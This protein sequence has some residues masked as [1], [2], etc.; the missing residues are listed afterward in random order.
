LRNKV[1]I[2]HDASIRYPNRSILFA[3]GTLLYL[4]GTTRNHFYIVTLSDLTVLNIDGSISNSNNSILYSNGSVLLTNGIFID[5]ANTFLYPNGSTL[6]ENGTF[7]D[8]DGTV[9]NQNSFTNA[10]KNLVYNIDKSILNSDGTT[11][12][13]NKSLLL[14]NG[15]MKNQNESYSYPNGSIYYVNGTFINTKG[16]IENKKPA[17]VDLLVHKLDGTILNPDGTI[18]Y[19][20]GSLVLLNEIML[21][22]DRSILYPNGS[23]LFGN[24]IVTDKQGTIKLSQIRNLISIL[25]IYNPDGSRVTQDGTVFY[26]NGDILFINGTLY[27]ETIIVIFNSTTKIGIEVE[28][29]TTK[30]TTDEADI[31]TSRISSGLSTQPTGTHGEDQLTSI[32]HE[33]SQQSTKENTISSIATKSTTNEA[34]IITSR[35]SSDISTQPTGTHGEDQLTSITHEVDQQS[36]KENTISSIATKSTTNEADIITS[37]ISSALSSQLTITISVDNDSLNVITT[38]TIYSTTTK[39]NQNALTST[40]IKNCRENSHSIHCLKQTRN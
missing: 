8:N 20:N 24:G 15:I 22:Q 2:D 26:P 39:S 12:F 19:S 34:D 7:I 36:S 38:T 30:S 1:F 9:T 27:S 21:N 28:Q 31:I 4:N 23:K 35:I 29:Q 3:N 6:F 37:R 32:T 14:L 16:D 33:V 17:S 40:T 18:L 5:N 25:T 11:L 13:S 10:S